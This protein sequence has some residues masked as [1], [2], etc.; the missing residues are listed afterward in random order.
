M[1]VYN[2]L[3]N[4]WITSIIYTYYTISGFRDIPQWARVIEERRLAFEEKMV[5]VVTLLEQRLADINEN[6]TSISNSLRDYGGRH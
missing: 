4:Y 1:S 5:A 6:L 3:M 2:F